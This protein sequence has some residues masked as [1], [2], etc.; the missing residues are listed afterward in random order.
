MAAVSAVR[1]QCAGDGESTHRIRADGRV[2]LGA[3]PRVAA[4]SR[5]E[6]GAVRSG[7]ILK[8]RGKA[9]SCTARNSNESWRSGQSRR[10]A[11]SRP[12]N[13]CPLLLRLSDAGHGESRIAAIGRHPKPSTQGDNAEQPTAS[14]FDPVR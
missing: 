2:Q 5:G 12:L 8:T 7:I 13:T 14:Y 10:Q 6:K 9:R 3:D 1:L 11:L 4:D